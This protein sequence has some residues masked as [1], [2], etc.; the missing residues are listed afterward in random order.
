M[1]CISCVAYKLLNALFEY[2]RQRRDEGIN[3]FTQIMDEYSRYV[4]PEFA[5]HSGN[6]LTKQLN[7]MIRHYV[8]T[9]PR[10]QSKLE[11]FGIS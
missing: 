3:D 6:L 2:A 9:D 1:S 8:A 7:E 10:Y 5:E 11:E 4:L